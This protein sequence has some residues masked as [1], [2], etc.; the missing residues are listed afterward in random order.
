MRVIDEDKIHEVVGDFR[1]G[2]A[3]SLVKVLN[4][5]KALTPVSEQQES[6][7]L[8]SCREGTAI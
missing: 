3:E 4:L 2:H 6:Y 5:E 1:K 8:E 7:P